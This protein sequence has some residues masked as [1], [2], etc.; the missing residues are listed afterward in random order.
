MLSDWSLYTMGVH[1]VCVVLAL[2]SNIVPVKSSNTDEDHLSI[3]YSKKK[4]FSLQNG[5]AWGTSYPEKVAII[6][7]SII[8]W[9]ST[10]FSLHPNPFPSFP[11]LKQKS[12]HNARA[13]CMW[14]FCIVFSYCSIKI[15][16]N[17]QNYLKI[18]FEKER[19]SLQN[20][21]AYPLG[22]YKIGMHAP[23][24]SIFMLMFFFFPGSSQNGSSFGSTDD[25]DV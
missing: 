23:M 12:V 10:S 22:L 25:I 13:W 24:V 15:I 3:W 17:N 16:G 8:L 2:L 11:I 5:Y 14:Y 7:S 20:G 21:C 1:C 9:I 19:F 18:L 6:P 4:W